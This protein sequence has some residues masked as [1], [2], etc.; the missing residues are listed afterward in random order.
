MATATSKATKM[1]PETEIAVLQFQVKNL[2]EKIGELK[3]DLRALHDAIEANAEETRQ[4][5]KVMR[6]QA[7]KEHTGLDNKVSALEKWRWMLMGAGIVIGS[8]GFPTVSALLK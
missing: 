5:L 8:M 6:E 4:M 2:E 7:I 3:V 1:Q